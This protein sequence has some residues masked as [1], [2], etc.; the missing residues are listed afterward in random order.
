[1]WV[2]RDRRELGGFRS[3]S[4]LVKAILVCA[5]ARIFTGHQDGK[6]RVWRAE[7]HGHSPTAAAA[8]VQHCRMGSLPRLWD[9]LQSSLCPSQ[10]FMERR[11]GRTASRRKKCAREEEN[12]REEER[13]VRGDSGCARLV[14]THFYA[15]RGK[16]CQVLKDRKGI[17]VLL[18]MCFSLFFSKKKHEW[19]SD[20][21]ALFGD[22]LW[23]NRLI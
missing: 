14:S 3:G 5:D 6:E 9:V 2:W 23:Q 4:S 1:M 21:G 8:V 17:W 19:G 7:D 16:I 12:T 13:R 15:R 18:E 11:T 10:Y 22:A 20:I